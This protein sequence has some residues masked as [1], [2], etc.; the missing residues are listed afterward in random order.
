M[1]TS[2]GHDVT[3][4]GVSFHL[5]AGFDD[6]EKVDSDNSLQGEDYIYKNP[7]NHQYIEIGVYDLENDN[8]DMNIFS[9]K[10]YKQT[11]IDGKEGY[12]KLSTGLRYGYTYVDNGK[13]IIMDVPVVLAEE[14]MQYEELLSEIIKWGFKMSEDLAENFELM[15]IVKG[16][17]IS[18]LII[19]IGMYTNIMISF[20]G[21]V[22]GSAFSGYSTLNSTKHALIYG[23][24]VGIVSS[25]L[26]LTVYTIPIFVI[27]GVFGGFIGKVLQNNLNL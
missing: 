16:I 24:I 10:G 25:F 8:L 26:I 5:P 27:L 12:G 4:N 11:T 18:F 1:V 22:I 17:V 9:K 2:S 3:V 19:I 13:Y 21:V 14:G 15:P 23:A 6:V 7:E 20:I